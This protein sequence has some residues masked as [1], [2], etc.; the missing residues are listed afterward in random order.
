MLRRFLRW[1]F[2]R[3]GWL[4]KLQKD[5]DVF[6]ISYFCAYE[7]LPRLALTMPEHLEQWKQ[8]ERPAAMLYVFAC[9]LTGAEP[10]PEDGERFGWH[11][12]KLSDGSAYLLVEYPEPVP[13]PHSQA[14]IEAVQSLAQWKKLAPFRLSPYFSVVVWRDET[15]VFALGA[16]PIRG[17]TTLRRVTLAGHFNL[18]PGPEPT[19][20]S[21]LACVAEKVECKVEGG[22][23][24][25]PEMST[26]LDAKLLEGMQSC[27]ERQLDE[28][29]GNSLQ[30]KED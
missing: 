23:V 30:T 14:D 17:Q 16:S 24:L 21:F 8:A 22:V 7:M 19:K 20:E 29:L 11:C 15:E 9:T 18:G 2:I 12:G 10:K 5:V 28:R 1:L 6:D 25:H 26:R 13:S 3:L 4:K 27:D